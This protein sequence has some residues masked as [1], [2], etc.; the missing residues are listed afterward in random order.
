VLRT[1]KPAL[2]IL[3]S[4]IIHV[5][6]ALFF[7]QVTL[8]FTPPAEKQL[9]LTLLAAGAGKGD[10]IQ[11]EAVWTAPQRV[12]PDFPVEEIYSRLQREIPYWLSLDQPDEALFAPRESLVPFP[13]IPQIA[14]KVRPHPP[15]D[16]LAPLPA[17]S[18]PVPT[19]EFALGSDI[20]ELLN[21][22]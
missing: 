8:S 7:S 21:E 16:L 19:A 15:E 18:K 2:F 20:R 6:F 17:E 5:S 3:F 9:T 11:K 13:E 12:D 1:G 4:V 14:E 22:D 10:I